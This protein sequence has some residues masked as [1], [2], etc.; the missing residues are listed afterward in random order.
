[1]CARIAAGLALLCTAVGAVGADLRPNEMIIGGGN[2]EAD[3]LWV[4]GP[5][6]S[7]TLR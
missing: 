4:S 3:G 2:C 1:M 7:R 6:I 5:S